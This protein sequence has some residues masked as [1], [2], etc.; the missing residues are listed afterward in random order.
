[1]NIILPRFSGINNDTFVIGEC[2]SPNAELAH[3]QNK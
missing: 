1:M 3:E 2:L